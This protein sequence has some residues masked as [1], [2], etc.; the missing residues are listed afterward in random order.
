[1]GRCHLFT[2]TFSF[3]AGYTDDDQIDQAKTM[4]VTKNCPHDKQIK[5]YAKCHYCG[6]KGHIRP[7]CPKYMKRIKS[8]KIEILAKQHPGLCGPPV[9]CPPGQPA[10]WRDFMKDPKA[11]AFVSS[12]LSKP[13]LPTMKS[14]MT[15]ATHAMM[16]FKMYLPTMQQMTTFVVFFQ[17][18][19]V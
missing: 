17:W 16:I 7:H 6:E 9:A 3:V 5:L 8:G 2:T 12:L 4:A 1:M 13:Y 10:P 15:M 14:I 18:L 19:V 11:K